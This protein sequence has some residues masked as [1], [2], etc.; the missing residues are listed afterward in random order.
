MDANNNKEITEFL[1][2]IE[3]LKA[4]QVIFKNYPDVFNYLAEKHF[5]PKMS[6]F[7]KKNGLEFIYERSADTYIRFNIKNPKWQDKCWIGF[8]FEKNQCYYGLCNNPNIYRISNENRKSLHE[9][10]NES[11]IS[12]RKESNWWPFYSYFTNLSLD[13]WENDII[14]SDNFLNDCIEKI[15][16]LLNAMEGIEF[17]IENRNEGPPNA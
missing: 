15:K 17:L 8:N 14:N 10:L 12:S 6:E 9:K 11:N 2:K 3:N 1:S 5:C 4:A 16:N 13:T 7:A